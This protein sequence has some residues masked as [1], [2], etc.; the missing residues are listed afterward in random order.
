MFIVFR[1]LPDPL[2]EGF[3][4]LLSEAVGG[5]ERRH[6]FVFIFTKDALD[7]EGLAGLSRNDGTIGNR[8]LKGI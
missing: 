4:L 6:M 7:N 3:F 5:V 8:A 2:G 1:P